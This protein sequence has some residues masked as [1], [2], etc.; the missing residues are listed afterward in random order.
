MCNKIGSKCAGLLVI[1]ILP[2][3]P[4]GG[5]PKLTLAAHMPIPPSSGI[6]SRVPLCSTCE[7]INPEAE[8]F[9]S[10]KPVVVRHEMHSL[11]QR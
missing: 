3:L 2:E 5:Y 6:H 1:H 10:N 4:V 9:V 8:K 11:H 7:F